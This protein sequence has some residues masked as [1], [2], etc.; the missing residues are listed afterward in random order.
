MTMT[1]YQVLAQRTSNTEGELKILNGVLGLTGEAG[2]VAD[3]VKKALFQ[4]HELDEEHLVEEI[5]DCLWYIAELATALGI[6]LDDVAKRNIDKLR[7]RYPDGF[8]AERSV[9]RPND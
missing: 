7:R 3:I 4:G 1:N 5:G 9:N 8:D 2:E 6:T